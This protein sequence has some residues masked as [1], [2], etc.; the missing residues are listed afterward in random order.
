MAAIEYLARLKL[1]LRRGGRELCL[2]SPSP[3][4]AELIDLA[5]LAGVLGCD[6]KPSAR[7][8][9]IQVAQIRVKRRAAERAHPSMRERAAQKLNPKMGAEDPPR[10]F[11]ARPLL[12]V[13]GQ[14]EERKEPCRVEKEGEL[15]DPPL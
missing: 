11:R 8:S 6:R 12:E 2:A 10:G 15:A 13:K 4:L 1:G 7:D 9:A 5:G 14:P 3:E